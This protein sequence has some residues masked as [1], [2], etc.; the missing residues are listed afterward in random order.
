MALD[1][2]ARGHYRT[3]GS[4]LVA[5]GTVGLAVTLG[6]TVVIPQDLGF[7]EPPAMALISGITLALGGWM[8][9]IAV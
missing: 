2:E 7:I 3:V 4:A 8:R 5:F 6:V 1:P 9:S